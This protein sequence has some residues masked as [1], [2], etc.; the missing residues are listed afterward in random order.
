MRITAGHAPFAAILIFLGV[1]GLVTGNFT[2]V[3]QP[4]PKW[5]P[6]REALVYLCALVSLGS[7][8]LLLWPRTARHAARTLLALLVVWFFAWRVPA[9]FVASLIEGTWSCGETLVIAGAAWALTGWGVRVPAVLYGLGMIPFGYAHFGNVKGTAS[10]VPGWL[11][12]H[13][14]W[15]YATGATFIAAGVAMIVGVSAR[16]AAALSALQMALFFLLVWVPILLAGSLSAFQ[17]GEVVSNLALVAAGWAVADALYSRTAIPRTV[18]AQA[19]NPS[20]PDSI[21]R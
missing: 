4:V 12:W 20:T 9:L 21:E 3:W 8:V 10:L 16:L 19:G 2:I 14:F 7:G 5:A 1:Q 17:K 6:A 15:A 13:V 18:S 11:P